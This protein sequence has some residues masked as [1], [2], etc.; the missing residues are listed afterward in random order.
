MGDKCLFNTPVLDTYTDEDVEQDRR[1][2]DYATGDFP[3]K[4]YGS[5]FNSSKIKT[6]QK[7]NATAAADRTAD[8]GR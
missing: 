6:P 8:E 1:T 3:K 7:S 5:R 2:V 4:V